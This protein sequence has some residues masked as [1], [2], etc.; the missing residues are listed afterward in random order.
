[1]KNDHKKR[2]GGDPAA[3]PLF[4]LAARI[5]KTAGSREAYEVCVFGSAAKG[6]VDTA[7]DIDFAI[8]G[9]PPERFFTTM[10]RV[11]MALPRQIDLV[12]L[13]EDNSFTRYLKDEHELVRIG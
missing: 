11:Q 2:S 13:D 10:G 12:D 7:N 3:H 1:M 5:L 6:D 8:S 4:V 9:L